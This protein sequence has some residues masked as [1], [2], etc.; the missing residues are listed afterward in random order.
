ML[1]VRSPVLGITVAVLVLSLECLGLI[2]YQRWQQ[3]RVDDIA[4]TARAEAVKRQAKRDAADAKARLDALI[5]QLDELDAELERAMQVGT[6][7]D[8][9]DLGTWRRQEA[10]RMLEK[11]REVEQLNDML[12]DRP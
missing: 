12:I 1:A 5:R 7:T 11:M 9:D 10:R 8:D 2:A 4:A 6:T 3:Q